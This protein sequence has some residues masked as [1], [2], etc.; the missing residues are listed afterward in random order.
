LTFV[1]G[2]IKSWGASG[3]HHDFFM[4]R[5]WWRSTEEGWPRWRGCGGIS[6]GSGEEESQLGN[7]KRLRMLG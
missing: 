7:W 1:G 6:A 2:E 3:A 4:L 5:R